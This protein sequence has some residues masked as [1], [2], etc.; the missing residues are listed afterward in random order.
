MKRNTTLGR[1][2]AVVL[3]ASILPLALSPG[4][5]AQA[6][7]KT[8]YEFTGS[9]DGQYPVAGL[10]FDQAGS[11]YG[12]NGGAHTDGTVFKLTTNLD[13][14]WTESVLYS[15]CTL[16]NCADGA[17]SYA[18]LIF[19]AAGNLYGTTVY[20]GAS[21]GG[22][23]FKLTLNSDGSWTESVLYNFCTLTNCADGAFPAARLIFDQV[24][25]LY[26]TTV[27]GGAHDSGTV[28]QLTPTADGR[29]KEKVLHHFTYGK[30]G[31]S[32]YAGLIFDAAGN[33]YGTTMLGGTSGS[34]NVFK[35]TPNADGSWRENVLH[36][37]CSVTN[38]G[39]GAE[40]FAGVIFDQGGNLYGTTWVGGSRGSCPD[41]GSGCGV[42]FE[43][44]PNSE[45][46]AWKERVVHRFTGGAQGGEPRAGLIFDR[47]GNLYGTTEL[48][49]AL[50]LCEFAGRAGCGVVFKLAPNSKGAWSET[51]LHRFVNHPGARPLAGLIFDAAGN[52]Y[53]TTLGDG[54]ATHGSV[55]EIT[56]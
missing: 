40:P 29:W 50:S 15:F 3:V 20:G 23:V 8:L 1:L 14:S 36:N 19:D 48:G 37:F 54:T 55:F 6:K 28:F 22:V 32:P 38:C 13:G 35:L 44:T 34:G 5:W 52:L 11:L 41:S 18:G 2:S 49:G 12:T 9:K 42:A 47:A 43:L 39:D 4:A 56:P 10:I 7:F 16:T 45:G 17:S 21:G 33:L 25:N 26:G 24:G 46:T 51:V 30:D 53:G 27:V 31:G